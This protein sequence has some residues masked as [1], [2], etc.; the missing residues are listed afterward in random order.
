[1]APSHPSAS[2][3]PPLLVYSRRQAP[4]P[5]VVST[6]VVAPSTSDDSISRHVAFLERRPPNR[7][8]WSNTCFS[9]SY[10]TFLSVIHSFSE[11]QSYTE[12]Y[13]DLNWV[14]AIEDEMFSLQKTN[15][16]ELVLLPAG[17][18]LV[19][20]KWVYKVKTHSDSSLEHYK[21]HLVAKG[22]SQ[23]YVIDYEETFTPVAKMTTVRT[24][25]SVAIVRNW[26]LYHLGIKTAFLNG[27]LTEEV[28]MRPPSGLLHSSVQVCCLQRT[29]YGLK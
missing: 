19:G 4:L 26:P 1:M 24:L 15:T 25:I 2:Y 12:A 7:L 13:Q 20:C 22:F 16:W 18:N 6:P 14:Q 5:P 29:L 3:S 11:P 23:E 10:R 8:G 27:Y 28:Y 21:A 17:K 9:A